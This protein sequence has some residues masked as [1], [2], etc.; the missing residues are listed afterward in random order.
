MSS[1]KKATIYIDTDD[2]ITTII[3]KV[4][5]S[6]DK[7]VAIVL[8]KRAAVLQSVVNMK[9]LKRSVDEAS[10]KIVLITSDAGVLPLAGIAGVH[11]AKT[12]QSKPE[13][14]SAPQTEEDAVDEV[15]EDVELDKSKSLAVLN[16]DLDEEEVA[17]IPEAT[18]LKSKK[19]K[20]SVKKNKKLKVPDFSKFRTK[21]IIAVL[22][23]ILL[24][25][26]WVVAAKVLPR[27]EIV[28]KTDTKTF[29]K[30]L[31]T[32]AALT[33]G[34][35][36][37]QAKI[38]PLE[39]SDSQTVPATGE[40]NVG[41]QASGTMTL[42][43]CIDDDSDHTIPKGS[44]FS[45]DGKSFI[46]TKDVKLG[47]SIYL[48]G[49]CATGDFGGYDGQ[50]DVDVIAAEGG[51]SFNIGEGAYNSSIA[52]INAYG[53]VMKGGTDDIKKVVSQSDIDQATQQLKDKTSAG[54]VDELK[55]L[56]VSQGYVPFESSF[57]AE[58]PIITASEAANTEASAVTVTG[59]AKFQMIGVLKDEIDEAIKEAAKDDIDDSAQ[60]IS[61]TGLTAATLRLSDVSE[62]VYELS[63]QTLVTAGPQLSADNLVKEILG[64]KYGETESILSGKAGV[65]DVDIN[66][67]PFW[68]KATPNKPAKVTIT[69]EN[70]AD[71]E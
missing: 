16:G 19:S 5:T 55:A 34:D 40:K 70:I 28:I 36:A 68:V 17:E 33:P 61:D 22:V 64:K 62:G 48:S 14:P 42:T 7:I 71:N 44:T 1:A 57:K 2:E 30:D 41:K 54:T 20:K 45:K 13:V 9:L 24:I 67:S 21:L 46:T 66:Y 23:L 50:K 27:A 26:G 3:D 10:K 29:S 53:S 32:T 56:L 60:T 6:K 43:N 8:P 12:L 47:E 59:S 69:I 39:K 11:V 4:V 52:G 31:K 18:P 58:V 15:D 25:G 38:E 65:V 49:K 35:D 37:L 51:A 63:I